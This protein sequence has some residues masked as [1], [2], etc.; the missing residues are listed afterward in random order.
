[1]SFTHAFA[2][3]IGIGH[4]ANIRSLAKPA[5]DA[6]SIQ[7]ALTDPALCGYAPGN[8][9]VLIDRQA[10]QTAIRAGLKWLADKAKSSSTVFFFFSGHGGQ[11]PANPATGNYLLPHDCDPFDHGTLNAHQLAGTSISS[12]EFTHALRKINSQK[13]VVIFDCCHSGGVGEASRDVFDRPGQMRAG[14]SENYYESLAQGTGRVIIASCLSNEKSWERANMQNGIFTTH[15]LAALRGRAAVRG[16]G[17]IHIFDVF[18][19]LATRV[20]PDAQACYDL[21][22]QGP[23]QQHPF[24]KAATQDNF[25]IALDRGGAKT[26]QPVPSRMAPLLQPIDTI[27]SVIISNPIQ[28][29]QQL[30]TYLSDKAEWNSQRP[31]L[32][33]RLSILKQAAEQVQNIGML[34]PALEAERRLA[35]YHALSVAWDVEDKIRSGQTG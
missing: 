33:L 7:Q 24:F 12:Q 18:D 5:N 4:Y 10:T 2:F 23:A 35:I 22:S 6:Q 13:L 28:G 9:R 8:V 19:D 31:A 20:P 3:V 27:R 1:M 11:D 15:L 16:D 14:L 34:T 21:D 17:L 29:I 26:I 32:E 30:I 25:A